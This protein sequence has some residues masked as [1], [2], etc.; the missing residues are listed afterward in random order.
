MGLGIDNREW[1]KAKS[2]DLVSKQKKKKT[3]SKFLSKEVP[4]F[5]HLF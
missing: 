1:N 3:I 4:K 5:E 2:D